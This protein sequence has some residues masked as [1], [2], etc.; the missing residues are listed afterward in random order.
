MKKTLMV[1]EPLP[2][3]KESALRDGCSLCGYFPTLGR[4]HTLKASFDALQMVGFLVVLCLRCGA[5]VGRYG[6]AKA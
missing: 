2:P 1:R 4:W 5:I 3:F 6:P